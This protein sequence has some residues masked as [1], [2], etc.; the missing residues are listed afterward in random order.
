MSLTGTQKDVLARHH[1]ATS[2]G[3]VAPGPRH[4]GLLLAG[5]GIFSNAGFFFWHTTVNASVAFFLPL[6]VILV[7]WVGRVPVRL[8]WLTSALPA[9]VLVQSLLLFPYH[10]NARGVWRAI[11]GL[12]VMNALFIYWVALQLVERNRAW[13]AGTGHRSSFGTAGD[14]RG[15]STLMAMRTGSGEKPQ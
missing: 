5:L 7:G 10:M 8:R 9:L 6:L 1:R 11:S 2:G 3:P 14:D 13:S 4:R 15:I 12:H